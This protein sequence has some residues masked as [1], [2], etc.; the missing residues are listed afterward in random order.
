[1]AALEDSQTTRETL[2]HQST[3]TEHNANHNT[4]RHHKSSSNQHNIHKRTQE[5]THKQTHEQEQHQ[6]IA[7]LSRCCRD[8]SRETH[9]SI[10]VGDRGASLPVSHL[11]LNER[12]ALD[13]R[14]RDALSRILDE[15]LLQQVDRIRRKPLGPERLGEHDGLRRLALGLSP[16]RV[17]TSHHDVKH[18]SGAPHIELRSL[19]HRAEERLGSRVME[20]ASSSDHRS[21]LGLESIAQSKV[22]EEHVLVAIEEHVVGLDVPVSEIN[23]STNQSINQEPMSVSFGVPD[24]ML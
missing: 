7:A 1:M 11:S 13:L 8:G 10:T 16:E 14:Q 21:V 3:H 4:N 6:P 19:D 22:A 5:R 2:S 23:Q 24:L 18:R 9:L 12:M 17:S 15:H 20:S